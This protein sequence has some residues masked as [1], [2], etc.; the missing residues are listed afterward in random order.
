MP[1]ASAVT[2]A[3]RIGFHRPAWKRVGR[4]LREQAGKRDA[5]RDR[6]AVHAS[7]AAQGRVSGVCL[8]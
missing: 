1:G 3:G 7:Q 8:R 5:A 2:L 6:P 4:D